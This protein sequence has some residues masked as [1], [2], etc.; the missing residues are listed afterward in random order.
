MLLVLG[1]FPIFAQGSITPIPLDEEASIL[2]QPESKEVVLQ[3][4]LIVSNIGYNESNLDNFLYLGTFR[5]YMFFS[6]KSFSI[7]TRG[8][9]SISAFSKVPN[10][11]KQT[12][13][14]GSLELLAF[15]QT[16]DGY[17][18]E[19]G[20]LYSNIGSGILFSNFADG[21]RYTLVY[22]FARFTA[23]A[24]YSADYGKVCA[25]SLQGCG[26]GINPYDVSP[27]LPPDANITDA[28]KRVFVIGDAETRPF[29][30][31]RGFGALLYSIDL[32]QEKSSAQ[33]KISYDPYYIS[34][35][36]KGYA[37][38]PDI[39]LRIEGIYQGGNTYNV[40]NPIENVRGNEIHKIN[41]FAF[42]AD[43]NY[44]TSFLRKMEH[45]ILFGYAFGSGDS[46]KTSVLLPAITNQYGDDHSFY[47]FGSYAAGLALKPRLSNLHIFSFGSRILPFAISHSIWRKTTL[48]W[49]VRYY[50]KAIA[51]GV[52]SDPLAT[53]PNRNVGFA[54]DI[55]LAFRWLNDLLF[56]TGYGFFLPQEAYLPS[57]QK[58]RHAFLASLT[59]SF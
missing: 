3:Y 52:I 49:K 31:L 2:K 27:N 46:D 42:R 20:R 48:E 18:L 17:V 10:S 25:L 54:A 14:N 56:Y 28:G 33:Q 6:Y 22:P 44:F 39:L 53:E 47:Y 9:F 11:G 36:L 4:G 50:L 8:K 37:Y 43:V 38:D 19:A 32:V 24:L 58:I 51:E 7:L 35:G 40:V 41:A 26:G 55:S 5:P 13:K 29:Y 59:L 21:V 1:F 45:A 30:G 23:Q 57:Q 15:Q 12:R 34:F 16:G